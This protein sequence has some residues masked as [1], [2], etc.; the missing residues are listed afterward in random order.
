M[1]NEY[2]VNKSDLTSVASAI[3]TKGGTSASLKFPT[4]F[5]TAIQNIKTGVELNFEV[6]GGTSR[7]SSPKE[8]TIWVNTSTAIKGWGVGALTERPASPSSGMV[9]IVTTDVSGCAFNAL[10]DNSIFVYP[11]EV[12]QRVN[13][14]WSKKDVKIYQAGSWKEFE[15]YL[16]DSGNQ[17][18]A[19]TG[20][21][22]SA[23]GANGT[24]TFNESHV[25]MSYYGSG[26]RTAVIYTSNKINLSKANTLCMEVDVTYN[27]S[28]MYLG[29]TSSVPSAAPAYYS[30]FVDYALSNSTGV[31]TIRLDVSGYTSGTYYVVAHSNL[32]TAKVYKIWLE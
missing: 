5:V 12:Y 15:T 2:A 27:G 32:A 20:G 11:I 19:T 13:A 4:G 16:Y 31:Q 29:L 1:A 25:F 18:A 7:P 6:V 9:W 26:G 17:F 22:K 23:V 3:R 10:K 30:E 24:C 21:W 28:G 14:A 8:N